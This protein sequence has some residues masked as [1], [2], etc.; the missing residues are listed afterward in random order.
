M[1]RS[2]RS[3]GNALTE[4]CMPLTPTS[5]GSSKS[6]TESPGYDEGTLVSS[7]GPS[8]PL[9]P[10]WWSLLFRICPG[11]FQMDSKDS[12]KHVSQSWALFWSSFHLGFS[13]ASFAI[14]A[15]PRGQ[16]S[17]LFSSVHSARLHP[18]LQVSRALIMS[19]AHLSYSV[20]FY[21]YL[22]IFKNP[23]LNH[24]GCVIIYDDIV[25]LV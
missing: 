10:H 2:G 18:S 22:L 17:E 15:L 4:D 7:L 11:S 20:L 16:R 19:L 1:P 12:P 6:W 21:R 13:C 9:H 5:T 23:L 3:C 8:L 25:L 14:D 24:I